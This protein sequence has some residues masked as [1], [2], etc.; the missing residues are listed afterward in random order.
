M[1]RPGLRSLA[2]AHSSAARAALDKARQS[3]D[4]YGTPD[5]FHTKI[6]IAVLSWSPSGRHTRQT[7]ARRAAVRAH[8]IVLSGC[9]HARQKFLNRFIEIVRIFAQPPCRHEYLL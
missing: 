8:A 3:G 4:G 6:R 7:A 5:A 9:Q 2:G 1:R